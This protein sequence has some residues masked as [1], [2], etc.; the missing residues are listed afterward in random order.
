MKNAVLKLKNK[1]FQKEIF[2]GIIFSAVM[3]FLL[4]LPQMALCGDIGDL[5]GLSTEVKKQTTTALELVKWICVLIFIAGIVHVIIAFVNH[6]QNLKTIIMSY[7][8]GFIAFAAIYA[9]LKSIQ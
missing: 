7:L 9:Y 4:L 1:D 2:N 3:A 5:S 8:G 6:S